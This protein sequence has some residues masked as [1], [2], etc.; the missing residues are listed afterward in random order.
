MALIV[1]NLLVKITHIATPNMLNVAICVLIHKASL[2][3]RFLVTA[4]IGL[5]TS[6]IRSSITLRCD[7]F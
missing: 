2:F 3:Y 7:F 4:A 5:V 1:V 6:A